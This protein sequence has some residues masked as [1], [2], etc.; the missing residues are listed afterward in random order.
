L[1]QVCQHQ[2]PTTYKL[3]R[4]QYFA[5]CIT[6]NDLGGLTI[7]CTGNS[8]GQRAAWSSVHSLAA[9]LPQIGN[10]TVLATNYS[11]PTSNIAGEIGSELASL[12]L[13]LGFDAC[14]TGGFSEG[15]KFNS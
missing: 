12:A 14:L 9:F 4:N 7:G 13:N 2:L 8:S 1:F 6:N 3:N 11:N 10:N 15:T 5:Q